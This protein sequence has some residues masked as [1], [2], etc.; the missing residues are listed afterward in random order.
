MTTGD[1]RSI[2]ERMDK[3]DQTM[4]VVELIEKLQKMPKNAEVY[5]LANMDTDTNWDEDNECWIETLPIKVVEKEEINSFNGWED[6]GKQV[7]VLLKI[8][9]Y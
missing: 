5:I 4:T 1:I 8:K 2:Q 6:S 7:N 3:D 9:E